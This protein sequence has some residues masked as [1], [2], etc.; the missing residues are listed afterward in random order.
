MPRVG[1]RYLFFLKPTPELDYSIL[2]AYEFG[3]KGIIAL[4]PSPQFEKFEGYAPNA[5]R[6]LV[7][8]AVNKSAKQ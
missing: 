7:V 8:E 1:G 2:I 5:L 6:S 4:D 3:E